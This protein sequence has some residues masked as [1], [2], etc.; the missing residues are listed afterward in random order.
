MGLPLCKVLP[1]SSKHSRR[2]ETEL[3]QLLIL[4]RLLAPGGGYIQDDAPASPFSIIG[5]A[6]EPAELKTMK[7]LVEV[8]NKLMR[9][10]KY[11]QRALFCSNGLYQQPFTLDTEPFEESSVPQ[12]LQYV[13]KFDAPVTGLGAAPGKPSASGLSTPD[14]ESM[15]SRTA[16]PQPGQALAAAILPRPNQDKIAIALALLVTSGLCN[17]A[18]LS[19]LKKDH[20]V[21]DGAWS[22]AALQ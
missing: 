8:F 15:P 14:A 19:S 2:Y 12:I 13:N 21:K 6:K 9:R 16:T 3:F 20:L 7:P 1:V 17:S 18:V 10:F 11:L 5:T 4:G 22:A